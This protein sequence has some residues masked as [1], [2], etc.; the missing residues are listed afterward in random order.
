MSKE[1]KRQQHYVWK[2]YL[3]GWSNGKH[4]FCLQDKTKIFPNSP[5]K[6][7]REGDFYRLEELT[8]EDVLI[9]RE[10]IGKCNPKIQQAQTK[11][12]DEIITIFHTRSLYEHFNMSTN[13]TDTEFDIV[14]NNFIEDE[15]WHYENGFAPYLYKMRDGC[16]SFLYE[17]HSEGRMLLKN[18][19]AFQSFRTRAAALRFLNNAKE[20]FDPDAVNR[21]WRV[22]AHLASYGV[23]FSHMG[24][25]VSVVSNNTSTQ[26][27]TS[28][29]PAINLCQEPDSYECYYPISPTYAIIL[30]EGDTCSIGENIDEFRAK[31]LNDKMV[32][33]S[34]MQ[35]YA[36]SEAA[37]IP[38]KQE[39]G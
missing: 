9:L 6:I 8:N 1:K 15:H 32:K 7:A 29:Q 33:S 17:E 38:Y 4:L 22:F 25:K 31:E 18:F 2:R 24:M 11:L 10:Y 28:D 35:I 16:F 21:L 26:F 37:L 14:F 34:Y 13:E 27:V 3:E 39:R 5:S 30:Y 36:T 23:A 19:I 20:V 12:L